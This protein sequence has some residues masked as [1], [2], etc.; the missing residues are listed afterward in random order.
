MIS[1]SFSIQDRIDSNGTSHL[2]VLNYYNDR[3]FK[4]NLYVIVWAMG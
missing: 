3:E 1:V 2:R 4:T